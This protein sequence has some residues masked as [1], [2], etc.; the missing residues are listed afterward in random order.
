MSIGN[1][2]LLAGAGTAPA[3]GPAEVAPDAG[4]TATGP[5]RRA[6]VLPY[7]LILPSVVAF[8]ALLGYPLYQVV[9]ISLLKLDLAELIQ[10]IGRAHV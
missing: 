5:G 4:S 1:E 7:L 10:Q 9:R 3:S 6:R 8:V 2:D